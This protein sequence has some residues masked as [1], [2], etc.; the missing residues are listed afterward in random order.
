MHALQFAQQFYRSRWSDIGEQCGVLQLAHCESEQ[1][2]H[3]QLHEKF[4]A[5]DELV[6]FVDATQATAI[7]G[8]TLTQSA[9]YFPNAGWINP[10][11]LCETL[12][13]HPAIKIITE[14]AAL[15]LEQR[16]EHWQINNNPELSAPIVIIA[17]A[18]DAKAFA[19]TQH[20]PIK[21]IRG[22]IT[23]L[24]QTNASSPLKTVVCSEGYIGPATNGEH[25]TGATFNLKEDTRELR[26]EDH[27]TN[28]ENLRSPLPDLLN[29]WRDLT[30]ESLPG[31]VAFRC[32]LPD[33]LPLIGAVPDEQ[34]MLEDFAP[35][36][37]NARAAIHKT[38]RYHSGL[39]I[40]IGHGSRGLAYTPL[41]AELLAAQ[42]NQETLP[43][44]RE[45]TNALN[46]AR[47]LIRDLIKN[48]R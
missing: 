47:F 37:K 24:P 2:L 26:A 6:Q 12:T 25:C 35:L 16:S 31:R 4:S 5:A 15:V 34:A 48:K 10:R 42:I 8:V 11:K 9:L 3:Q 30:F 29:E 7:A 14:C 39:F 23:Y 40:N 33:Y 17:N 36:R 28:L 19:L 27:H 41:C 20:L 46:P 38:G 45:L 18:N 1:Q 21:S 44:P 13:N 43:L 22:Q 32:T